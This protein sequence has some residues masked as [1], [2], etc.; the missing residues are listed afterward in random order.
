M[1]SLLSTRVTLYQQTNTEVTTVNELSSYQIQ[2]N[3][4]LKTNEI[5]KVHH[6]VNQHGCDL[7]FHQNQLI[8]DAGHLPKMLSFF[9]FMNIDDPFVLIIDGRCV[10]DVYEEITAFLDD[11]IVNSVCRRKYSS[12]M[13][14]DETSI[15]V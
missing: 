11:T 8:A 9:L 7:Y 3:R 2:L 5:M 1:F 4:P 14:M 13:V 10:E 12:S 6:T 15:P